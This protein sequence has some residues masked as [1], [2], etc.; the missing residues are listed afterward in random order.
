MSTLEDVQK[1]AAGAPGR[2]GA[3][4][5]VKIV[6][7]AASN[8]STVNGDSATKYTVR[9]RGALRDAR[10]FCSKC[11]RLLGKRGARQGCWPTWS[12]PQ[13][14]VKKVIDCELFAILP[15]TE[16]YQEMR[17]PLRGGAP[18]GDRQQTDAP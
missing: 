8:R 16:K 18:D 12:H 6:E 10:F 15:Y 1:M 3:S 9:F 11:R 4:A 13:Q 7:A 14:I 17:N 5:S 2:I